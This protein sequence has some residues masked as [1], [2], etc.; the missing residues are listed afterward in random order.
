MYLF[1]RLINY[2]FHVLEEQ[3][4]FACKITYESIE[5]GHNCQLFVNQ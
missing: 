4:H 5:S 1:E 2:L 3:G